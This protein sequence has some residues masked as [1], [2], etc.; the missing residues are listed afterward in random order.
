MFYTN[1]C[2][3]ENKTERHESPKAPP[4]LAPPP[5]EDRLFTDWSSIDSPRERTSQHNVSARNTE[6]N[7]NQT[8]NQTDHSGSEP[9]RIEAM[10]NT[11]SDVMTFPSACRQ[12]SQV[13]TRLID[14]ET[15]TS[16][17]EVRTQREE[18]RI[19]NLSSNEVIISND[20][21]TQM[22]TSHSGLS[23]YDTEITGGSH[24][25]THTME[26]IPQLDSPTSVHSRRR[27]LENARTEQETF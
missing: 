21:D 8:D 18:T 13:G 22:P 2:R 12:P 15:N 25:R 5:T 27:I 26:M 11:L 10:G 16:E 6:P 14:R 1:Q 9:A 7:I 23:L 3:R 19:D 17:V 4:P 20:R 24:I